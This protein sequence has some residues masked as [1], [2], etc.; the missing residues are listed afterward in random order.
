MKHV[1]KALS[2]YTETSPLAG[3]H[4]INSITINDRK[5]NEIS[6]IAKK[7]IMFL[8]QRKITMHSKTYNEAI[9]SHP[10]LTQ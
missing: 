1:S 10:H 9:L 6:A 4:V 2:N 3:P 5:K 7:V 8:A